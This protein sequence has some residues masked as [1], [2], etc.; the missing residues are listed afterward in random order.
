[1]LANPA[2]ATI[3]KA[4]GKTVAQT[5][6]RFT[7][8]LGMLPLTGTTSEAHMREDLD[9]EDFTLSADEMSVLESAG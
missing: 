8:Q 1:V 5:V 3:A 4:H 7:R 6:F 9:I 2:V